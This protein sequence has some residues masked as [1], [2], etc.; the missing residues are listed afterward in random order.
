MEKYLKVFLSYIHN[1][2]NLSANTIVAYRK[3]IQQYLTKVN[4]LSDLNR[5][6]I[7]EFLSDISTL[8]PST[9]RRKLSAVRE[10]MKFL[11]KEGIIENNE[12]LLIDSVKP[13]K[14]LPKVLNVNQVASIIDSAE[15]KRDRALLETMYGIGC[16]V[17]ELVNIKISDIDFDNRMIRL[18]GKGNKERIVPINNASITA[19]QA[20]INSRGFE[21]DYIFST[22]ILP[23][24]PMTTRNARRIVY[25]YGG[26]EVH[27]HMF[28]HSY[29]TH[30]HANSVDI[31]VIQE[32]LGHSD[33]STT[34]IY[35]HIANEQMSKAY[36][37]A[38]PRG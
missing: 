4:D 18:F 9:R 24:V 7:R 31:N 23:S 34:T 35:T 1:E 20:H 27:P 25:K 30:L 32:L 2:K 28:R 5:F 11:N 8:A 38:H 10:F 16:R 15:N 22:R 26:K 17:E 14:K 6:T 12:A 33:I 37:H 21:S 3:D 19:I 36:R 13:E 29:A